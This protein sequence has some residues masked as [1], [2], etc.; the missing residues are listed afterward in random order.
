ML[1]VVSPAKKFDMGPMDVAKVTTFTQPIFPA[2]TNELAEVAGKLSTAEL[3]KLMGISNN[4]ADLNKVRFANFGTQLRKP[5]ALAFAGDTYQGLE[6]DSFDVDEINWAQ[7]H[8]RIISGLYGIL[9]P[10]DE[11]EPYRLEMG[12]RLTTKRGKSLYDYWGG[13][14]AEALNLQGEATNS[15]YLVNCASKEYFAAIDQTHLKIP[16]IT[17]VFMENTDNGPKIVSF[18]AKKA[19]GAMA[20]FIV[21]NRITSGSALRD[22]DSGGYRFR[23]D[24]SS[25]DKLVF[26]R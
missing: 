17:P 20:R 21:A 15:K 26:A 8:L 5:A 6:A 13:K 19:R 9:R 2:E 16:V 24:L 1:I 25:D 7:D 12:S 22:F 14:L 4:L 10:L 18:Y 23:V 11:I 3:K